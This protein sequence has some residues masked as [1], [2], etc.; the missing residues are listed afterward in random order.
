MSLF[1]FSQHNPL[2]HIIASYSFHTLITPVYLC[3]ASSWLWIY[4]Y[5]A[6]TAMLQLTFTAVCWS[7]NTVAQR[8]STAV[9]TPLR[10]ATRYCIL[11]LIARMWCAKHI[12]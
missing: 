3:I 5:M 7:N 1:N 2:V 12:T 10:A 8:F 4:E 9:R 6:A 11:N